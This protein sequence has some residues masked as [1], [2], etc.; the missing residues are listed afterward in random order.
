MIE[1]DFSFEE[2]PLEARIGCIPAGGS[3]SAA[4]LLTLT[5]GETEE[6]LQDILMELEIRHI[7]L[8]IS[9]LSAPALSGEAA[10]RLRREAELVASG[11]LRQGLEENDPLRLYL[12]EVD[13]LPTAGDPQ[14]MAEAYARG[15]DMVIA[16]L[17]NRMLPQVVE[18]ACENTG[19]GVLLMDL[20]QE[21]SMGLWQS[22]LG[23]HGGDFTS[24]A[25][26]WIRQYFAKAITMQARENGFGQKMRQAMEDYRA[27]DERL[28]SDLGRNPTLEEIAE[29]LHMGLEETENVAKML[30]NARFISRAKQENEP[31]EEEDP[32]EE[33][34]VENTA[35]FQSRQ[36]IEELMSGLS[37]METKVLT[38]RFGLEG[39]LPLNPEDT[40]RKLGMTPEEVLAMEAAALGK[41]R[42]S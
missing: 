16:N 12:E 34:H 11:K 29:Q 20:I 32:E 31:Q 27:V 2:T 15:Q 1:L 37:E 36:R 17:T 38:L 6:S 7:S 25:M 41:M 3:I 21:G 33:T 26:W 5:E 30:E 8:D 35:L 22:I 10:L 28:L 9:N 39:G 19:R 14:K 24:H 18:M 42:N 23:Y 13:A 40:G 4:E